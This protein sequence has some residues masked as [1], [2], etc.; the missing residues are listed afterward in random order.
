MAIENANDLGHHLALRLLVSGEVV[1]DIPTTTTAHVREPFHGGRRKTTTSTLRPQ[2]ASQL[3]RATPDRS[4]RRPSAMRLLCS[5]RAARHSV[6]QSNSNSQ[7]TS[8]TVARADHRRGADIVDTQEGGCRES[9]LVRTRTAPNKIRLELTKELITDFK[10]F[11]QQ[12]ASS[13]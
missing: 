1:L 10:R 5:Q 7:S 9:N 2:R 8:R 13:K 12:L 3:C 11:D 6:S 4:I